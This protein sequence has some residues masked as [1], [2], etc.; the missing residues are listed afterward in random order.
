MIKNKINFNN[1]PNELKKEHNFL[2]WREEQRENGKISKKP[3]TYAGGDFNPLDKDK[4]YSFEDVQSALE[5]ATNVSGIGFSLLNNGVTNDEGKR[6]FFYDIDDTLNDPII[7]VLKDKTYI[8]YSPS[9]NGLH[10]Y[11]FVDNNEYIGK[12]RGSYELYS[13]GRYF[14]LTGNKHEYSTDDIKEIDT[15]TFE[16]LLKTVMK[17]ESD[18]NSE[19]LD[20]YTSEELN[21]FNG[22]CKLSND[23][24]LERAK[25]HKTRGADY[26]AIIKGNFNEAR[27]KD[28]KPFIDENGVLDISRADLSLLS[29]LVWTVQGDRAKLFE[30]YRST[31]GGWY[32]PEKDH[33]TGRIGSTINKV[34]AEYIEYKKSKEF[35]GLKINGYQD[36]EEQRKDKTKYFNKIAFNGWYITDENGEEKF[37]PLYMGEYIIQN[38]NVVRHNLN[39][40]IYQNELGHYAHDID[41]SMLER[42]VRSL[43]PTLKNTQI[44]EVTGYVRTMAKVIEEE[45]TNL[46]AVGNGLLDPYTK[47]LKP[48]NPKYFI[49]RKIP[50]NYNPKAVNTFVD[51]TLDKVSNYHKETYVNILEM[52]ATVLYPKFLISKMFYLYGLTASNGKSTV[53]NMIHSTFND[54]DNISSVKLQDIATDKHS[55]SAM[56]NKMANIIDDL[57]KQ[58]I[59]TVGDLKSM[60]TGGVV[61]IRPTHKTGYSIRWNSPLITASNYYPNFTE[62]GQQINKRLYIIPFEYNFEKD[63]KVISEYES[64]NKIDEESARERVLFLSVEALQHLLKKAKRSETENKERNLLTYNERSQKIMEDFSTMNNL[65]LEYVDIKQLDKDYFLS[66]PFTD[67]YREYKTYSKFNSEKPISSEEFKKSVIEMFGISY[68]KPRYIIKGEKVQRAGFKE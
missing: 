13:C 14:T 38:L 40:Y 34:V 8:E 30:V 27:N 55:S 31:V 7:D 37:I 16:I 60:I 43:S 52:F 64:M 54:G 17:D 28:G 29:S 41:G 59:E 48:F 18:P 2:M 36:I 4:L 47:E 33:Q 66:K 21:T 63:E 3:T 12:K 61:P 5:V 51:T 15:E 25:N 56:V 65:V 58:E 32:R 39:I 62:T 44:K 6:L 10:A 11:F 45:E 68:G 46:I 19:L 9:G 26:T 23:E 24:I 22:V 42:I 20:K 57:P 49:T 67:L 35:E 50:T 53:I 1:V